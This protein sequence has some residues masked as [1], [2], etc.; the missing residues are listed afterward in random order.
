MQCID[1]LLFGKVGTLL[2][3]A[4]GVLSKMLGDG[5]DGLEATKKS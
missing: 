2:E 1:V 5:L 3:W 4:D